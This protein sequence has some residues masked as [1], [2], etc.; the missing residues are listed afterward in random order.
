MN[1]LLIAVFGCVVVYGAWAWTTAETNAVVREL[2]SVAALQLESEESIDGDCIIDP[3]DPVVTTYESL[4]A[5]N[6]Q[7]QLPYWNQWTPADRKTAFENFLA[8]TSRGVSHEGISADR[9]LL[10]CLERDFA[11]A[12]IPA[13]DM[14]LST[15]VSADCRSVAASVYTKFAMPTEERTRFVEAIITNKIVL[16][17]DRARLLWKYGRNKE[18]EVRSNLVLGLCEALERDYDAGMTNLV[19]QGASMLYRSVD[20]PY[21]AY[22]LDRLFLKV[23]PSYATSSNRLEVAM[24]GMRPGLRSGV[25]NDAGINIFSA[26]TNQLLNAAQPLPVVDG[27]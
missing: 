6:R 18:R 16:V 15:N 24:L 3:P 27:L 22:H 10:F 7:A 23:F 1:R 12:L 11:G 13:R 4:F 21:N 5:T 8:E 19:V 26:I 14:L 9:A 17:D 20:E 2:V 25:V